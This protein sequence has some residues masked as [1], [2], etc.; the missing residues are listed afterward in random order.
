MGQHIA[1]FTALMNRARRLHAD[2]AGDTARGREAAAQVPQARHVLR[3]LR[4]DLRVG[5]FEVG[6]AHQRRPAVAGAGQVDHV[7]IV[8]L[9]QPVQVDVDQA[10]ARGRT[11]VAEQS[12]LD[13]LRPQRLTQQGVLPQ[14][15]LRDGQEVGGV[16]VALHLVQQ[17]GR[18][19]SDRCCFPPI[20]R[21]H[22]AG[23][24]CVEPVH[25][26][27]LPPR[28]TAS[29]SSAHRVFVGRDQ[30]HRS[31]AA[32]AAWSPPTPTT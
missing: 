10:E 15:N 28:S 5:A 29:V 20:G 26:R 30:A 2:V 21:A 18:Q 6:V 8:L 11:P 16:P 22:C 25:G 27:L 24:A 14:V 4:I 7:G 3:H 17:R 1:Q 31:G 19:R 13:V 23:D 32:D 9:D 12:R